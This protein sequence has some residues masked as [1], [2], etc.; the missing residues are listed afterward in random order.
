MG[1]M[2]MTRPADRRFPL[3]ALAVVRDLRLLV[4][5]RGRS[6]A[7][8]TAGPPNIPVP[9]HS[10]APPSRCPPAGC[11]ARTARWPRSSDSLRGGHQRRAPRSADLADQDRP[12]R[13]AAAAV[14]EDAEVDADDVAVLQHHVLA[15]DAVDDDLVDRRAQHRRVAVVAEERRLGLELAQPPAA[16]SLSSQVLMPGLGRA[17]SRS[18]T[19]ADDQVGLAQLG[20]L[21]GALESNRHRI[22]PR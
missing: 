7:P 6:R 11:R 18:S 4:H 2:A 12:R 22:P 5:L 15:R 9:P 17:S 1:S 20:D 19:S 21:G 14:L 16:I 8:R 13:V 10:A 3:P